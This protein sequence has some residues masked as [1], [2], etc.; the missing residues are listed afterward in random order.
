M[1]TF[2]ISLEKSNLV[3]F[4]HPYHFLIVIWGF[5]FPTKKIESKQAIHHALLLINN[6]A[7][8]GNFRIV[9]FHT[10][11]KGAG[12]KIPTLLKKI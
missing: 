4:N 6:M 2:E 12:E 7:M 8:K 5:R 3:N 1:I 9:Y 10:G 11:V